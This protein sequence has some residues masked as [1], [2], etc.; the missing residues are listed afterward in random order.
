MRLNQQTIGCGTFESD[1]AHQHQHQTHSR[2]EYESGD[3]YC[4]VLYTNKVN[5]SDN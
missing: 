1:S 4:S 3:I 2:I 5:D